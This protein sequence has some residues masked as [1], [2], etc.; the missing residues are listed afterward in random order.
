MGI[1]R[2]NERLEQE[3]RVLCERVRVLED[4]AE[5]T[6]RQVTEDLKAMERDI[7]NFRLDYQ[8]LYEKARVQLAKLAKRDQREGDGDAP[9]DRMAQY[10]A[11]LLQRKLKRG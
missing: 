11:L 7:D 8:G 6:Q 9:T 10:R 1:F 3:I 4:Q 5:M 2:Q